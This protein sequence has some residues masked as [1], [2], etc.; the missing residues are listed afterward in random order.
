MG[1]WGSGPFENDDAADWRYLLLDGGGP[2]VVA[3]ALRAVVGGSAPDLPE[4]SRA[5]AA[6][7]VVGAGLG[8]ADLELPDD[9]REWLAA[10]D[11]SA[12]PPLAPEAVR[13]L[14]R[15][16]TQ[17]ELRDLWSEA[18]DGSWSAET[19]ALRDRIIEAATGG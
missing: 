5:A 4:A 11:P 3:G 16:L 13:A 12:W 9:L 15:V 8:L 10:T 2:E 18:G 19:R 17:S 6:A 14:D 1:A 7:A